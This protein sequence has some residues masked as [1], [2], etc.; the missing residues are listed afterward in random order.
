MNTADTAPSSSLPC[1]VEALT[2]GKEGYD[3]CTALLPQRLPP[4][5][6]QPKMRTTGVV[7]GEREESGWSSAS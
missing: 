3:V 6:P 4:V 1:L 5:Q 7:L 2:T